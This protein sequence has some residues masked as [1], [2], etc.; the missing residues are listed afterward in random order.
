MSFIFKLDIQWLL[1]NLAGQQPLCLQ[2]EFIAADRKTDLRTNL[3]HSMDTAVTENYGL[4]GD[5]LG[6]KKQT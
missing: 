1:T 3:N 4:I 6:G 2:A 5:Y